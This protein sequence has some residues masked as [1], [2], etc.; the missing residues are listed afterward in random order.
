[1]WKSVSILARRSLSILDPGLSELRWACGKVEHV[2]KQCDATIF[3]TERQVCFKL[4]GKKKEANEVVNT[5]CIEAFRLNHLTSWLLVA[6]RWPC[7][8]RPPRCS[9]STGDQFWPRRPDRITHGPHKIASNVF[10]QYCISSLSIFHT[11]Y[12]LCSDFFSQSRAEWSTG[13]LTW[14]KI[15]S[16][17]YEGS[18]KNYWAAVHDSYCREYCGYFNGLIKK[19]TYK[20]LTLG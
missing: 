13:Y 12:S 17:L 7:S 14:K 20:F 4:R 8:R 15:P 6:H 16:C 5:R 1:M 3:V 18:N 10:Y 2:C 11:A 19:H 9:G